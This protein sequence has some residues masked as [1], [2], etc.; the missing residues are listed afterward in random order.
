MPHEKDAYMSSNTRMTLRGV[1]WAL[2]KW[3]RGTETDRSQIT[4]PAFPYHTH[5]GTF[6]RGMANEVTALQWD[7]LFSLRIND[8]FIFFFCQFTKINSI[9]LNARELNHLGKMKGTRLEARRPGRD[10]VKAAAMEK[11]GVS[12]TC[13]K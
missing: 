4:E 3:Q 12:T 8:S 13:R 11:R 5:S 1:I 6:F 7:F 10:I 2:C 9:M